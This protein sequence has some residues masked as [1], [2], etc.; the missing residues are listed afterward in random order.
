M[1]IHSIYGRK[2]GFVVK[3]GESA[4]YQVGHGLHFRL[5]KAAGRD[6]RSAHSDSTRAPWLLGVARN[7]ISVDSNPNLVQLDL[8]LAPCKSF[9]P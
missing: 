1:A 9:V 5:A 3:V 8:G 7:H 6:C 2:L 4:V